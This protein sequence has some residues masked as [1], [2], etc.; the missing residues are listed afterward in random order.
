[1][2]VYIEA[3]L[4]SQMVMQETRVRF[5]GQEDALEKEW[6]NG[7]NGAALHRSPHNPEHSPLCYAGGPC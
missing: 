1:M 2:Y 4:V 3:S 6:N 5:L 7:M